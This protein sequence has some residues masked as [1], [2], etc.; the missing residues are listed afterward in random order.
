MAIGV[1][2]VEP[3]ETASIVLGHAALA[4]IAMKTREIAE[5]IL[6][7]CILGRDVDDNEVKHCD[8]RE[9]LVELRKG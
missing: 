2:N 7:R 1:T 9:R 5:V 8:K 4:A 3:S 6:S